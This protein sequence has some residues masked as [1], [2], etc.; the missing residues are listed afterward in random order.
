MVRGGIREGAGR[1]PGPTGK[2][3]KMRSMRLTDTEYTLVREYVKELRR[4]KDDN[5]RNPTTDL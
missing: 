2:A 3:R 4:V 1:P 5:G